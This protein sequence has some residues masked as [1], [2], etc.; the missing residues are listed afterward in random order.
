MAM[1]DDDPQQRLDHD[2]EELIK[3]REALKALLEQRQRECE[4]A[5]LCLHWD[6]CPFRHSPYP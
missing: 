4:L 3:S 5:R 6:E 1:N 2:I